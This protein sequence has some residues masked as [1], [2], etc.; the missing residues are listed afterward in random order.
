VPWYFSSPN[1]I[2]LQV[3]P[4]P[5]ACKRETPHPECR[6]VSRLDERASLWH[7]CGGVKT[8]L[9]AF[10]MLWPLLAGSGFAQTEKLVKLPAGPK[11]NI[12]VPMGYS[13]ESKLNTDG[14]VQFVM[15]NPVWDIHIQGL[16]AA[17][18]DPNITKRAWQEDKLVT[19][20][21]TAMQLAKEDDYTFHPLP[22]ES[23][24]GVYCLFTAQDATPPKPGEKNSGSYFTGGLKAW[25]G[26][27]VIF[28]I[29]SPDKSSPE[30]QEA[31]DLFSY[32]VTK[33]K[34]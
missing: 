18:R 11:V 30:Y 28:R 12:L 2:G 20:V 33:A 26:C 32:Y 16:V 27:V 1:G 25:P 8:R 4:S 5:W 6:L 23:G 29:V 17:E 3:V 7:Q 14:S 10:V 34:G 9:I 13:F 31:M 21:A 22:V 15:E 24:S 19:F